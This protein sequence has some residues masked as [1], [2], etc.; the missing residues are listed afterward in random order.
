MSAESGSFDL[1]ESL[2]KPF[3]AEP[4]S[5]E[6]LIA[7]PAERGLFNPIKYHGSVTTAD[8]APYNIRINEKIM[9][10]YLR[11]EF[12]FNSSDLK[13]LH[14]HVIGEHP[15]KRPHNFTKEERAFFF[16][17]DVYEQG[18]SWG[19]TVPGKDDSWHV[20]IYAFNIWR[21]INIEKNAILK[22]ARTK[23]RTEKSWDRLDRD[24]EILERDEE[25]PK[26]GKRFTEYL[27]HVGVK[28]KPGDKYPSVPV[29]R[30]VKFI[31]RFIY[32]YR[33]KNSIKD[34]VAVHETS[35]AFHQ[36]LSL[37]RVA[38][39]LTK[40]MFDFLLEANAIIE[41]KRISKKREWVGMVDFQV[42]NPQE[43]FVLANS[44]KAA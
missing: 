15:P 21:A 31:N 14:I 42:Q 41:E 44:P 40:R 25:H 19:A 16:D 32:N 6:H 17:P 27:A 24:T 43:E 1:P 28:P 2:V 36:K 9:S 38:E 35:H 29:E 3:M 33:A 10:E 4:N 5:L 39:Q 8:G 13:N 34:H 11:R 18:R 7:K 30:A 26:L 23:R 20:I 37:K 22:F 12:G